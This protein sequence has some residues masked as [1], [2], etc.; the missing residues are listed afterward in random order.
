MQRIAGMALEEPLR[1][2][3]HCIDVRHQFNSHF[4]PKR[5][6]PFALSISRKVLIH[7]YFAV[8]A[9]IPVTH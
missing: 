1:R 4:V 3:K 2:F 7:N 9:D 5:N 6:E 8:G